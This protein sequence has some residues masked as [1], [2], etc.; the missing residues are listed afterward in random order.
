MECRVGLGVPGRVD[1][2]VTVHVR[3]CRLGEQAITGQ[4]CGAQPSD[5]EFQRTEFERLA[6]LEK[7]IG[8]VQFGMLL[9]DLVSVRRHGLRWLHMHRLGHIV[10]YLDHRGGGCDCPG[11]ENLL[12]RKRSRPARPQR[13]AV[14]VERV[15][16][17]GAAGAIN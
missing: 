3:Q 8:L 4:L 16:V 7:G 13:T 10:G 15:A 2:A 9:A 6:R 1:E 14:V 5:R 11:G 17:P 12:P